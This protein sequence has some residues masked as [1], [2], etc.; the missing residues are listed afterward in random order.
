MGYGRRIFSWG[1]RGGRSRF[2]SFQK[3]CPKGK[4][5]E[6][7]SWGGL[8]GA[9]PPQESPLPVPCPCALPPIFFRPKIFF[10]RIFFWQK[11]F[12][13]NFFR[14]SMRPSSV[15]PSV[16]RP[17]VV[18]PPVYPLLYIHFRYI[19]AIVSGSL[20]LVHSNSLPLDAY[21]FFV[22]AT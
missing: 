13:P 8:G 14:P 11:I 3:I 5:F 6:M 20:A 19:V 22:N 17:S 16:V 10:G 12:R 21:P 1:G 18:R 7:V 2:K 15:R 9:L 4:F